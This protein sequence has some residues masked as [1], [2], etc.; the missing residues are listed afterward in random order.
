MIDSK[1]LLWLLNNRIDKKQKKSLLIFRKNQELKEYK[2]R[3]LRSKH[4]VLQLQDLYLRPHLLDGMRYKKF[5]FVM[6]VKNGK[7]TKCF[8]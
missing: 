5:L 4:Y 6:E 2:K 7:I 3:H 8:K 1:R